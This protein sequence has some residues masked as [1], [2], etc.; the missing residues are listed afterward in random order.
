MARAVSWNW[1]L[2]VDGKTIHPLE[3][4]EFGEGEEGRIEVADGD[5]KY[6]IRDQIWNID[7]IT[8]T[9]LI[10]KD[11]YY[12]RIMQDWSVSG[13]TKNVYL[14]ARD[15]AHVPQMTFLLS[16][17][18]CA[19]GKHNAFNRASKEA[20]KKKFHLIPDFVEEVT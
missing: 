13:A 10:K 3:I 19:M 14:I 6:K 7:E 8:V 4:S 1:E 17:T 18:D 15:M 11:R 20:D 12:Y 5:R 9:I 2:Q 16:D